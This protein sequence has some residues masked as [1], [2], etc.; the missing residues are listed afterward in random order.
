[1]DLGAAGHLYPETN[2][3]AAFDHLFADL[4]PNPDGQPSARARSRRSVLDFVR[5][6]LARVRQQVPA[7]RRADRDAHKDA[8]RQ[9]EMQQGGLLPSCEPPTIPGE[10]GAAVGSAD[11]L[12]EIGAAMFSIIVD[13]FKRDI[14]RTIT[15]MWAG[16][17]ADNRLSPVNGSNHHDLSHQNDRPGLSTIDRWYSEQ[18]ANLIAA[19]AAVAA[20]FTVAASPDEIWDALA[21][22]E[23]PNDHRHAL[24]LEARTRRGLDALADRAATR[25]RN[26]SGGHDARKW[27]RDR[28]A[29][30]AGSCAKSPHLS[31]YGPDDPQRRRPL[32]HNRCAC[33]WQVSCSVKG[34]VPL[35]ARESVSIAATMLL[36][37]C[38]P[39]EPATPTDALGESDHVTVSV[40]E[41][42]TVAADASAAAAADGVGALAGE[43]RYHSG[44]YSV[45]TAIDA[46]VGEMNAMVRR[47]REATSGR[48]QRGAPERRDPAGRRRR[49]RRD[50]RPRLFCAA[51]RWQPQGPRPHRRSLEHAPRD[52]GR[53]AAP[54]LP[55]RPGRPHQRVLGA[56]ER[57]RDD[58]GADDLAEAARRREVSA[59]VHRA[60]TD[61]VA[62]LAAITADDTSAR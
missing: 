4:D 46:V 22:F 36:V 13:A 14:S 25:R 23:S 31:A 3:T 32:G 30:A 43:Y 57:R 47:I 9:L 39:P 62:G 45:R 61:D 48:G 50:R 27:A 21:P 18:T 55:R 12:A 49:H 2:P 42:S 17:A 51:G 16:N 8:V 6:D 37:G 54:E 26:S 20:G 35:P 29:R 38:A 15:F 10:F 58:G 1:V 52:A 19:L 7:W 41:P 59:R 33:H 53:R 56:Q 5:S 44:N 11:A 40:V 60:V 28:R 24:Y 34:V